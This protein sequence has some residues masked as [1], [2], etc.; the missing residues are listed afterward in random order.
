MAPASVVQGCASGGAIQFGGADIHVSFDA[1]EFVFGAGP[2]CGWIMRAAVAVGGYFG[3]YP[4]N[5]VR[6]V[7]KPVSGAG[8]RGGKTYGGADGGP[9]IVIPLG[10]ETRQAQLDDDW[11]MTH[12]MVHLAVPSVPD[13][14]EW[15]EEGIATYVEPIARAQQGQLSDQRVWGDM[16]RDMPQGLPQ[17]GDRGLDRT[18][19]WGRIYWGGALFCLLADVGIRSRTNNHFGLRDALRGVLVADGDIREDWPVS[20]VLAAGDQAVGVPVLTELYRRMKDAPGPG[21]AELDALWQ[22]L[23]VEADDSGVRFVA[24]APLAGI[25]EAITARDK[26]ASTAR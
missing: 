17:S 5:T 6:I 21:R 14:S 12:E 26:A 24:D 4:V 19:T 23:G 25:R 2:I 11:V 10:R 13:D 9:L 20:R 22:R 7:I 16:F 15:L 1:K 3:R 8:V 18:P